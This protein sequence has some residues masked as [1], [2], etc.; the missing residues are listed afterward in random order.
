MP[1]SGAP[2]PDACRRGPPRLSSAI[3]AVAAGSALAVRPPVAVAGTV[4]AAVAG[5]DPPARQSSV[6][7]PLLLVFGLVLLGGVAAGAWLLWPTV[8]RVLGLGGQPKA[9]EPARVAETAPAAI[10]ATRVDASGKSRD[11]QGGRRPAEAGGAAAG[12][13]AAG[14]SRPADSVS[15][16]AASG[17]RPSQAS[18]GRVVGT[19]TGG[20]M[21]AA[22][23]TDQQC[24]RTRDRPRRRRR[25]WSATRV[26]ARS[27]TTPRRAR[28]RRRSNL[29]AATLPELEGSCAAGGRGDRRAGAVPAR[30]ASRPSSW[31]GVDPAGQRELV[32]M[33]RYDTAYSARVT[34][35]CLDVATGRPRGRPASATVE[36]TAL[37][38]ERTTQQALGE[39]VSQVIAQAR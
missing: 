36:Y 31:H 24:Q 13:A 9:T 21:A 5:V 19:G 15:R 20:G 30:P 18:P 33:N 16:T 7:L 6:L 23:S 25:R 38:A 10:D 34:I 22:A 8:S 32:Y 3:V 17:G 27:R 12:A 39:V 2:P 1:E 14:S 37:S 28:R 11:E 26:W 29:D 4:P 35:T